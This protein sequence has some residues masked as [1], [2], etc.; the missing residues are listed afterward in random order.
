MSA[1]EASRGKED[2]ADVGGGCT[3]SMRKSCAEQ[4]GDKGHFG[5]TEKNKRLTRRLVEWRLLGGDSQH[6]VL[7]PA[8]QVAPDSDGRALHILHFEGHV[9]VELLC[10][11]QSHRGGVNRKT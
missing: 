7:L 3:D 10:K 1:A 4:C 2:G 11:S 5:S 8:G 6:E 9:R